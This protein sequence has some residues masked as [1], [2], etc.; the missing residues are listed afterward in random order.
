ML[1]ILM[2]C[3]KRRRILRAGR[4]NLD[5]KQPGFPEQVIRTIAARWA[6][7]ST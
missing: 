3:A 4:G 2:R 7:R 1:D 6:C 5:Q